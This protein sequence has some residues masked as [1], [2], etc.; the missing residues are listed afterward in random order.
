MLPIK[1]ETRGGAR[2]NAGRKKGSSVYGESTKAIRVPE[3]MVPTVKALLEGRKARFEHLTSNSASIFFP[4]TTPRL[5]VLP[6]FGG[7]VA[8]GFPSPADDYVEKNLDLNE[9]LVQ[10]PAATFF[11]RAQGESMLGAGIHPDDILVVDRS[12][13]P[14]PG[15][16]VICALNGELTVKRLER[17]NEQ[18]Q[19]KAE[20]PAYADIVIHEELD[21]VIWG[22]VTHVIH[23]V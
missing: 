15:K 4:A 8:A 10:K 20:N 12:L 3:S 13:E 22:V 21:M 11:V 5:C 14:V 9:L 19:L 16:I 23:A 18:W 17:V 1:T 6:L 7:K 2:P